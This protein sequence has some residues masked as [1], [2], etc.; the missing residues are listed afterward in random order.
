M[1][2]QC[3]EVRLIFIFFIL[4]YSGAHSLITILIFTLHM[5]ASLEMGSVSFK[6]PIDVLVCECNRGSRE[7]VEELLDFQ[8]QILDD[9]VSIHDAATYL[10]Q[11]MAD[12]VED[13]D[14]NGYNGLTNLSLPIVTKSKPAYLLLYLNEF[15][16]ED[17]QA[18]GKENVATI[19][20]S[21]LDRGIKIVL[22]HE[23][24]RSLGGC[25]FNLFF[26]QAPQWLYNPP[27]NLFNELAVPLYSSQAYRVVSLKKVCL[28][29]GAYC[30]KT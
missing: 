7:I 22:V 9:S 10:K 27:Y 26:E 6:E 5:N 30:Q 18:D 25:E 24:D 19:A 13:S 23:Q 2:L 1:A 12:P 20:A 16:F 29:L 21:C 11:E 17:Y 3:R 28:K 4:E 8:E 14:D 15:T